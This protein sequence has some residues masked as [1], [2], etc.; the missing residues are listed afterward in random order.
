MKLINIQGKIDKALTSWDNDRES[1][2]TLL[3]NEGLLVVVSPSPWLAFYTTDK[4]R[5]R[6]QEL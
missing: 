3:V 2:T 4:G 6:L 5:A 1:D